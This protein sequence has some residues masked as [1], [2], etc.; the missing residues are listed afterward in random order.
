M[1]SGIGVSSVSPWSSA[2]VRFSLQRGRVGVSVTGIPCRHS[3]NLGKSYF[4]PQYL[5]RRG[6]K[7]FPEASRIFSTPA[8]SAESG[9]GAGDGLCLCCPHPV[10]HVLKGCCIGDAFGRA[11]NGVSQRP[12][13]G[14]QRALLSTCT[15]SEMPMLTRKAVTLPKVGQCVFS[16][17][18]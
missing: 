5:F 18:T 2:D 13:S 9:H 11:V 3:R 8:A 6:P 1:T 14:T 17:Y 15:S 10:G 7:S 4:L 16:S 12:T